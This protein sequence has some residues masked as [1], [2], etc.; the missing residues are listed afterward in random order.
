M[1][2]VIVITSG[3]GGVGKT[4][5]SANLGT[6]LAA[7]GQKVCLVDT[8]IGLRNLDVVLGLENRIVYDLLDV[9][10][11][12]CDLRKALIRD[13]QYGE[14][15]VLIPA[16]QTREKDEVDPEQM[17]LLVEQLKAEYDFV[18]LDSPA[19]IEHGFKNAIAGA[20]MAILITTPEVS[21]VRDADRVVGLLESSGIH[22]PQ[23]IINRLRPDM[24]RKGDMMDISDVDDILRIPIL[25]VVPDD[26][27]IIVS[28]NR[29]EPVVHDQ[30]SKAGQAYRNIAR[31]LIGE[32]IPLMDLQERGFVS[33]FKK[34]LS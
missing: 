14:R 31:R 16:A 26:E 13:K 7:L 32:E 30:K 23:V 22:E 33:W 4:T 28:T 8:D 29:G 24:V 12:R 34:V 9:L 15:L 6:G 2:K 5:T 19:G 20:D 25:G 18:I 21:A 27:Q 11:G 1:G 10:E 3:K 17:R